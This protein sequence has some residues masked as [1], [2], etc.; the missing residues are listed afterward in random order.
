MSIDSVT[1]E[2]YT[3]AY[4]SIGI[5]LR[6]TSTGGITQQNGRRSLCLVM[7]CV[8]VEDVKEGAC[9]LAINFSIDDEEK[10]TREAHRCG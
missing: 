4:V 10:A 9:F 1:S 5:P 7:S 8:Q 2:C 6:C 3:T